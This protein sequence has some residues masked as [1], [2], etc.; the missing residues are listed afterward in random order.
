MKNYI[1]KNSF[2]LVLFFAGLFLNSCDKNNDPVTPNY[3]FL[4]SNE[5]KFDITTTQAKANLLTFQ[6][7]IP[8][9]SQ[10]GAIVQHDVEVHKLTYKTT[11]QDKNIQASGLVSFPKTAGN[12]PVLSFQNGTNTEHSKAP[13]EN[14]KD[15]LFSI[16][17]SVAS[18]GFIVV[19]PD[20]IGFGASSQYK[21]PYLI[22]KPTTQSILDLIRAVKEFGTEDKIAA[23]ATKDLF[24]FGYSQ[25]GWA[26]MQ[27]QKTIETN[28]ASEF[29]LVASSCAAGPYSLSYINEFVTSQ[30]DYPM[31]YF[32]A[33]LLNSYTALGE[34]SNPLS[35][36]IQEPY[37]TKIPGLFDG[38]HTGG[39]I[40]SELTPKMS[41]LL[42]AEY[43]TEYTTNPKFTGLKTAFLANS[44]TAWNISTPTRLYHGANDE[45]I[46]VG[47]TNK[48]YADFKTA[49]VPDS[50]LQLIVIPGVDHPTGV[51]P[52][53]ISTVLWFLGL[54]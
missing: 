18:M 35:D 25:G 40:N 6:A 2:L 14:P 15:E 1:L 43:R 48:M 13:T 21:H 31:P 51:I 34:I 47:M 41:N 10:L 46:P 11:F 39:T 7:V 32:L 30:T 54:K 27:L 29:N 8:E 23:K 19:M 52:V 50:K 37:A 26:T 44:I 17:E 45:F 38:K 33:Y 16:M 49:G 5:Y 12:Y 3:E 22:A 28:Y 53:G 20:Y 4:F 36:F 9:S 24:I 42:T